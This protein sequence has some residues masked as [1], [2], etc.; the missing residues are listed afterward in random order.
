MV[1]HIMSADTKL[2]PDLGLSENQVSGIT[3]ILKMLLADEFVFYTKLRNFHW[4]VTGPN[5]RSLH[6]ILEEQ[7]NDI[8][9]VVDEIAECIRQY[10]EMAPGTLEEFKALTRHTEQ[11][12]LYPNARTMVASAVADHELL[13]RNLRQDIETIDEEYEDVAVED[14]LTGLMEQHQKMA[15]MLRAHLEGEPLM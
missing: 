8:A 13:I 4:N 12:G 15:W 6:L 7:Y 11:P 3:R 2:K 1:D 10:G 9:E 5:F 14:F